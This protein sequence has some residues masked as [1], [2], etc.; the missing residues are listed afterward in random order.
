MVES[1]KNLL[2]QN[3]HPFTPPPKKKE[4][5][6]LQVSTCW[7]IRSRSVSEGISSIPNPPLRSANS[8]IFQ[9]FHGDL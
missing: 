6:A 1:N 8:Y 5:D 2:P 9:N 4:E 3:N 7:Q